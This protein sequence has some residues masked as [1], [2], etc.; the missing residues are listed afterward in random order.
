M[1]SFELWLNAAAGGPVLSKK[2][3]DIRS[4]WQLNLHGDGCQSSGRH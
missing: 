1:F 2:F 3:N 4:S